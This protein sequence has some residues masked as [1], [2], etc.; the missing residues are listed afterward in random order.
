MNFDW[1]NEQAEL[2]K[3]ALSFAGSEL[4]E[5]LR[6]RDA[7]AEF[8]HSG[9]R[10]CANFG[11][12]GLPIP[13]EY[14]GSAAD[15]LTTV[16]ILESLG[17]GCRDNGLIFSMNAQM[18]TLAKPIAE[19]GT[20]EQKKRYLPA[21]CRGDLIGG[22]AMTEPSSGSDAYS[23]KTTAERRGDRYVLNGSKVFVTNAPIGDVILVYATLRS[24]QEDAGITGFLVEKGHRGLKVGRPIEK[25]GLRTSPMAE[26]FF[27]DC[28]V[29]VENRLG[30]EGGGR[31]L[32]NQSMAWERSFILASAVGAM[33]RLLDLSIAYARE[34]K[35]FDQ[36][37]GK[38]Q[39]VASKIV[40]MKM[41]L[42]EARAALYRTAWIRA[43]G[44]SGFMDA[45]LTKLTISDNWVKCAEDALQV[46]G[47]YGYTVDYEIERELRDAIGSRIYSGT[48]EM[49][50]VIVASLLG[51]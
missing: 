5:G 36:P 10:K 8:N 43:S 26:L 46:H 1:T 30:R 47:G 45:A 6:E 31:N 13:K 25:M 18:W 2:R 40:D 29:P 20:P 38:F 41:R 35:Q 19:F 27:D 7:R 32:F 9:W 4:N 28:E 39:L 15:P 37:I 16:A 17:R 50:R 34:R 12:Q 48:S 49:Q 21:L 23:L 51:L 44:R 14:G 22:N 24:P 33:E 11:I 42:E 3:A